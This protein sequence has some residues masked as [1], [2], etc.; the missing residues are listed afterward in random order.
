MTGF[1]QADMKFEFSS[2]YMVYYVDYGME[3]SLFLMLF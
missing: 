1:C 3:E 2:L